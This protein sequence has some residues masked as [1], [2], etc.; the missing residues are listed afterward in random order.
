CSVSNLSAAPGATTALTNAAPVPMIVT[1]RR[2]VDQDG[3]VKEHGVN[4]HC[5]YRHAFNGFAARLNSGEIEKLKHDPRVIAVEPDG[6]VRTCSQTVP[7]GVLRMGITNFPVAH[8]DGSDHRIDVDVA[9]LDTG[10][11]TNHPDLNVV[12][13]VGF[14]DPGL[15]GN[16][17]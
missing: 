14:A 3:M 17:W 2:E 13:A 10:I 4:R 5:A 11:Q 7:A 16:D 15:D 6:K 1:L 9:V 8:I 12:Q